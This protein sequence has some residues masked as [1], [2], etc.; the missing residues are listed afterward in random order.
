ME[1]GTFGDA[2]APP[3][4]STNIATCISNATPFSLTITKRSKRLRRKPRNQAGKKEEEHKK[5]RLCF[6]SSGFSLFRHGPR[7]LLHR[8]CAEAPF[9]F[10]LCA[11]CTLWSRILKYTN[12]SN[13]NGCTESRTHGHSRCKGHRGK[14][15]PRTKRRP[16]PS[17]PRCRAPVP[18]YPPQTQPLGMAQHG[19]KQSLVGAHVGAGSLLF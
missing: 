17:Q 7:R 9:L 13:G 3:N 2:S 4:V 12:P 10:L 1:H 6:L 11:S 15:P 16:I 5:K 8:A 14:R 18:P 19:D